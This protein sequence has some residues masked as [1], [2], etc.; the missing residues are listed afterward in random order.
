MQDK[1]GKQIPVEELEKYLEGKIEKLDLEEAIEKLS[2]SG[3]IFQPK[4]GY[5]QLV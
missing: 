4:K 5:I 3:D 2:I 1:I